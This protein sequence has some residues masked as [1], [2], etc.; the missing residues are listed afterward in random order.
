MGL[1]LSSREYDKFV[2]TYVDCASRDTH[3]W[4]GLSLANKAWRARIVRHVRRSVSPEQ[5]AIYAFTINDAASMYGWEK[6]N[7]IRAVQY[8]SDPEYCALAMCMDAYHHARE[9]SKRFYELRARVS[10]TGSNLIPPTWFKETKR[11][12]KALD[13]LVEN[14]W[15][16]TCDYLGAKKG[17]LATCRDLIIVETQIAVDTREIAINVTRIGELRTEIARLEVVRGE[18]MIKRAKLAQELGIE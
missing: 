3:Q 10:K 2:A 9:Q 6:G 17:K 18:R 13:A 5:L 7:L 4:W 8:I 14:T 1:A 12:E 16:F 15:N 11:T